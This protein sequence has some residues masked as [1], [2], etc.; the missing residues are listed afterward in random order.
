[1]AKRHLHHA[2][3][4]LLTTKPRAGADFVDTDPWRALRIL[5][6]FVE[7][8]D[9]LA[10]VGPCC[11]IFGSSRFT[12]SNPYYPKAVRTAELLVKGGLAVITGGGPGIMEAANRGAYFANG[13]SIGCNIQLPFEQAPNPYQ[14]VS[15]EFRYFFVRKM[16]F[17]KYAVGFII[18]PGGFGTLDEFFEALTLSQTRKI[19]NF[20]IVLFGTEHWQG[21]VDWIRQSVLRT[22]CIDEADLGLFETVDSPEVA[23]EIVLDRAR[24]NGHI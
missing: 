24:R 10:R 17:V 15:L 9:A 5:G 6:E 2:D 16:M 11:A 23:A 12:E 22:G 1:M 3:R 13:T 8:F 4:Q 21:L 19:E 18:F 14:T 20:P 7:G